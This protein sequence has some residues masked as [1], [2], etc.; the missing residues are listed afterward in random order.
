ML[1]SHYG[2][3]NNT[4]IKLK[5]VTNLLGMAFE[6]RQ[7]DLLWDMWKLQYGHSVKIPHEDFL[8]FEKYKETLITQKHINITYEEIEKEMEMIIKAHEARE[9]KKE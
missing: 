4:K 3:N 1:Y 8:P 9:L 6:K 5:N 7:N 2:I